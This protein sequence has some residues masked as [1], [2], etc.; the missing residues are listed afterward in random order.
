MK[1][2]ALRKLFKQIRDER[3]AAPAVRVGYYFK[4]PQTE[5]T[6]KIQEEV[7]TIADYGTTGL[8]MKSDIQKLA[9][10]IGANACEMLNMD[11][12]LSRRIRRLQFWQRIQWF[13][14]WFLI[15]AVGMIIYL[16][17]TEI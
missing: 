5:S 17:H 9:I 14:I 2:K 10:C 7:G 8:N 16:S 6:R 12:E 15:G 1:A 4:T 11:L 13:L 3:R